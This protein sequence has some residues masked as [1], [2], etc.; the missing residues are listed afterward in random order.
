MT[1]HE[2]DSSVAGGGEDDESYEESLGSY[3]SD[4]DS[5]SQET[6]LSAECGLND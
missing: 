2:S 4:S 3:E 6:N 5:D 1:Y